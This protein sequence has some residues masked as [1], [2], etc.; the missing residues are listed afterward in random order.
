METTNGGVQ[1]AASEVVE[2]IQAAQAISPGKP[3]LVIVN[4][5]NDRSDIFYR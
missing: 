5:M 3:S 1:D 2:A 4:S